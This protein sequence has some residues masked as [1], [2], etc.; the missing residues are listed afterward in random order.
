MATTFHPRSAGYPV[1][2]RGEMAG[3]KFRTAILTSLLV[4]VGSLAISLLMAISILASG[5]MTWSD[6]GP[7]PAPVPQPSATAGLDL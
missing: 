5:S 1:A 7:M 4:L 6:A 3:G 2:R